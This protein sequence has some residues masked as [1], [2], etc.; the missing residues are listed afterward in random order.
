[1]WQGRRYLMLLGE[2]A[3]AV[4]FSPDGRLL[5]TSRTEFA[6]RA[7]L[8]WNSVTGQ[9]VGALKDDPGWFRRLTELMWLRFVRRSNQMRPT[10][11]LAFGPDGKLL[12]AARGKAV[13][14]WEV[15]GGELKHTFTGHR[16][17]AF[18]VAFAPD[19]Q[20]V[21]SGSGDKT[22]RLWDPTSPPKVPRRP[23][24]RALFSRDRS[25]TGGR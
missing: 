10:Y 25:S 24:W 3:A 4:A 16:R 11:G 7:V 23:W 8:L 6:D 2:R 20:T 15:S 12:A 1:L 17:P 14:V 22:V 5:A 9:R 21:A 19:G 18:A 13:K